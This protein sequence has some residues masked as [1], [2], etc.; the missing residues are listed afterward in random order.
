MAE[1][2]P[3]NIQ[4]L[5]VHCSATKADQFVGATEI[6]QWHLDRGWAG[7][8][9]HF[10]IRRD[11]NYLGSYLEFGRPMTQTGAHVKGWN[12][13]SLGICLVGGIDYNG[14]PEAN[15]IQPQYDTLVWLL[16]FLQALYPNT[17]VQGHKDF[18]DV[19]KACP[20]FDVIPWWQNI[21]MSM[22]TPMPLQVGNGSFYG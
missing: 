4:F 21:S 22:A 2:N 20:C 7:I 1:L 10:V 18:P 13:R 19:A 11:Q 5:A 16:K 6:N 9:Y 15:F 8:G 12:S 14:A 17:T 3:A